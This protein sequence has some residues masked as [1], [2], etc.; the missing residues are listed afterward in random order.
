MVLCEV[1]KEEAICQK[2]Y[3]F[4]HIDGTLLNSRKEILNSTQKA[5]NTLKKNGHEIFLATGRNKMFTN[6]I[7]EYTGIANYILNNGSSSYYNDN[8]IFEKVIDSENILKIYHKCSELGIQMTV[9]NDKRSYR[10]FEDL[11]DLFLTAMDYFKEPIPEYCDFNQLNLEIYQ[12]CIF[13]EEKTEKEFLNLEIDNIRFIRW[14]DSGV[15]ILNKDTSKASSIVE[16]VNYLEY[17]LEDTITFGD[18]VNDLEMFS[19]VNTS[20]A[21]ENGHNEV[22]NSADLITTSNDDNGIYNGLK[23]LGLI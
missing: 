9:F 20:V 13:H 11:D 22:K 14:H 7:L 17:S 8:L 18:D 3:F 2:N 6:E 4:W 23:T 19:V 15:D 12:A 21:M 10:L 16:I 5:L 1:L